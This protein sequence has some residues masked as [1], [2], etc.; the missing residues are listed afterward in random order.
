MQGKFLLGCKRQMAMRLVIR[1]G[2][3]TCTDEG[4]VSD[5]V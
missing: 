2:F 3:V 5:S 4:R 1:Q